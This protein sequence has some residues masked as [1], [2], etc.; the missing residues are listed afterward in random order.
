MHQPI[1]D[2]VQTDHQH[3][4]KDIDRWQ[5]YLGTW[6]QEGDQFLAEAKR[7]QER[8]GHHCADLKACMETLE[9]H[10]REIAN[11][12]RM[13][14]DQAINGKTIAWETHAK[15]KRHHDALHRLYESLQNQCQALREQLSALHPD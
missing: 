8:V 7:F 2:D 11:A 15:R 12:E 14:A 10:R 5:N 6:V 1:A 9:F 3:W 4:L 13:M